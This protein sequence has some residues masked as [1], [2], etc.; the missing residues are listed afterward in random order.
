[1]NDFRIRRYNEL[2][3]VIEEFKTGGINPKTRQPSPGH[4]AVVGYYGRLEDLVKA[5]VNRQITPPEGTL[6][7]QIPAMLAELKVVEAR[8]LDSLTAA[9]VGG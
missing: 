9:R 2:N 5:L 4:W 3:L 6:A 8:I 1:M 7:E